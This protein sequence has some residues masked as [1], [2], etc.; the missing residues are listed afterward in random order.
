[1]INTSCEQLKTKNKI[2]K[3]K[4]SLQ[5]VKNSCDSKDQC[6]SANTISSL[7]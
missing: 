7:S 3:E 2:R 5:L 1:M 6:L 4:D